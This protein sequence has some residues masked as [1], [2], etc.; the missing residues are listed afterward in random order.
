MIELDLTDPYAAVFGSRTTIQFA[1]AGPSTFLDF[2]GRELAAVRLNGADLD[3]TGWRS[4]RIRLTGLAQDNTV[5]VEGRMP[6]SNDGEGLH[7]HVDPA[8]QQTYLYAMSFLD[9]APRWF[10]CF[11]QPDLKA[12]YELRVS[13]PDDWTVLGNG[14]SRREAPGRWVIR[15]SGPLP[16]YVVT[17]AVSYTHL[18]LPTTPYV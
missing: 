12:H 14:P 8:D 18:T 13:A 3:Q 1:S 4:G 6:Y 2:R 9:A 10:A 5:V 11:D 7:R 17:L 15:P 16:S